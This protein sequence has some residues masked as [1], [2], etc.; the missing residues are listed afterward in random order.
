MPTQKE[1]YICLTNKSKIMSIENQLLEKFQVEEL[2]KRLEFGWIPKKVE[3]QTPY[4]NA[5]FE[6]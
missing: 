3:V 6:V 2:E 1:K 4:G 5:T